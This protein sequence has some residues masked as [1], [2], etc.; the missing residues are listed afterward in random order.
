MGASASKPEDIQA[1]AKNS[2]SVPYSPP[3]GSPNPA[4]PVVYL[5]IKL[6]RYG[7]GTP[8]GRI[9]IEL[10]DDIVP[11]TAENFKQLCCRPEG[12]GYRNSRF[13][14]VIPS[15]MCQGGDFTRDN[16]TGGRSIYGNRFNDENFNL[17]HLGPGILSS[18]NAGPNTNGSQFFLCTVATPWL[19]NRHVVFGQVID[20]FSVVKAIEACGSK[21]GETSYDVMISD[22]G[23]LSKGKTTGGKDNG[24]SSV[25][26]SSLLSL[27]EKTSGVT[28]SAERTLQAQRKFS[29]VGCPVAVPRI[30]TVGSVRR[31]AMPGARAQQI[32]VNKY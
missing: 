2:S 16:G 10:K 13:H 1:L 9:C 30:S 18:A 26:A 14:R 4:N 25:Q 23:V 11:Q 32:F 29:L 17:K 6:G 31:M 22:C 3:L 12:E 19:D 8:L 27:S 15:F 28:C 5:D 20:G 24:P 21:S 7:D